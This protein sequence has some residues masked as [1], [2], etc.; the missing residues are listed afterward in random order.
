M[1]RHWQALEPKCLLHER[2]HAREVEIV[3]VAYPVEQ[4]VQEALQNVVKHAQATSV[5]V[6]LKAE[7]ESIA[8]RISDNGIGFNPD[9][10][11]AGHL[12]LKSMRKRMANLQGS[13]EIESNPTSETAI[14]GYIPLSYSYTLP[15]TASSSFP[16]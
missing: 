15:P 12:G 5:T 8:F 16:G 14:R 1:K 7:A 13:L 3:N 2:G 10:Q 11:F 6:E 9:Q 4:V